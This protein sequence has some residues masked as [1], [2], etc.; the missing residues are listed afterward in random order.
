MKQIQQNIWQNKTKLTTE[1]WIGQP[2]NLEGPFDSLDTAQNIVDDSTVNVES[3]NIVIT[4][5]VV[6][7][8]VK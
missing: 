3:A 7:R 2:P 5:E 6:I 4:E 1:Y 8:P